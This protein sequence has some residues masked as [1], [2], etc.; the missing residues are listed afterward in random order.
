VSAAVDEQI[1]TPDHDG[2]FPRLSDDQIARLDAQGERRGTTAGEVLFAE[3]EEGYDFHVVLRGMVAVI[4]DYGGHEERLIAVHGA[5][6]FLGELGL[7]TGQA[8]F[9]TAVV[10]EPGEVLVVEVDRVRALINQDHALADLLLRA[11]FMRRELLIGLGAGFRIIGSRYSPDTRRLREFVARNRLPHRWVDLERDASAEALLREVGIQPEDAP[12]VIWHGQVLRNPSNAELAR[13]VGLVS[14]ALARTACDLLVVGAGPAGLAASVYGAS[15]GLDTMT[16]DAIATGGQAGT[17]SRIENYLGFPAGISGA[18]LGERAALQARKFGARITVP[19]EA[20]ALEPQR[21]HHLVRLTDDREILTRTVLIASGARYRRLTIPR[22]EQFE[23]VSVYYAA[24]LMEAQMCAGDEVVVVGAGNSAGQATLFLSRYARKLRLLVRGDSIARTMS[25]Y[26]AD[27]IER[28]PVEIMLETEVRELE[29]DGELI[30]V[31]AEEHRTGTR[32]RL[33]AKALF[34]FIGADPH[35][36]WLQ[37]QVALDRHGFVLT[38]PAAS[39][40]L[41]DVGGEPRQPLLLETS[42]PG[43]LAAG[44]VRSGSIKRVASAV[45]EGSMAV[46]FAHEFLER[47]H[48]HPHHAP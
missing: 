3:G 19:G 17:S 30:A 16:L 7:L 44:D 35:T 42:C 12:V 46:R 32:R 5:G 22:L 26:L 27:R 4:D 2:A 33:P 47:A 37:G 23:G 6:R 41:P 36:H 34:V 20:V 28:S 11:Y 1:E 48:Q 24:T 8:A 18:E 38:G 13:A 39:H 15:E 31:I 29:G 9:F 10:R 21:D 43:V 45:G 14:P 40:T 25:R